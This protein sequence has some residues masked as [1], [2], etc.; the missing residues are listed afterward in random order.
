M[1]P[2]SQEAI[3]A[4][5]SVQE[6]INIDVLHIHIVNKAKEMTNQNGLEYIE[7]WLSRSSE[8]FVEINE[9]VESNWFLLIDESGFSFAIPYKNSGGCKASTFGP[10]DY[11]QDHIKKRDLKRKATAAAT[12]QATV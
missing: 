5:N 9:D 7:S 6:E 4:M 12:N 1:N 8:K 3:A 10:K 11:T 2:L